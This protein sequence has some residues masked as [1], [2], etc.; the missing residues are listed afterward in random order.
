MVFGGP[1]S[2]V[3][4]LVRG[5]NYKT[6]QLTLQLEFPAPENGPSGLRT[7]NVE[8]S[9]SFYDF[10]MIDNTRLVGD[11]R[12]AVVL[13]SFDKDSAQITI[14]GFPGA[15]ASLKEKP[16]FQDLVNQLLDIP[17][18]TEQNTLGRPE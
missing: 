11:R 12:I 9:L 15:Y 8:F 14:A 3:K 4:I 17:K 7:R 5:A 6:R 18:V 16:Y 2:D 10:P 1:E 13:N